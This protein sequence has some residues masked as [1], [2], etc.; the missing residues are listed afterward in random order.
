MLLG[1]VGLAGSNFFYY[2]SIKYVSV[3]TGIMIQYTAPFFVMLVAI[4]VKQEKYHYLKMLFLSLAFIACFFAVCGGDL[5]Y[6]SINMTGV[7]LAI[8][9]AFTW[10]F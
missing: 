10:S 1:V 7:L 9:S 5:S 4:I 8:A 3:S 2:T 6:F